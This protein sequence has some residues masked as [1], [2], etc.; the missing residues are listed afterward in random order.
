MRRF[1]DVGFLAGAALT[2]RGDFE[3]RP[4]GLAVDLTVFP[5]APVPV[6]APLVAL[7]ALV[8]FVLL[9]VVF[10]AETDDD[11]GGISTA[12]SPVTLS[13]PIAA[14]FFSRYLTRLSASLARCPVG[15]ALS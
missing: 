10:F 5:V 4:E 6:T 11:L 13:T 14:S 1:F 3:L 2:V 7:V 9:C 12:P 15:L 8:A